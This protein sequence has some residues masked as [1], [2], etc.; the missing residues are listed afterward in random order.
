[1]LRC[2][3][4]LRQSA[5]TAFDRRPLRNEGVEDDLIVPYIYYIYYVIRPHCGFISTA[6]SEVTFCPSFFSLSSFLS[7]LM[8]LFLF[9]I[10]IHFPLSRPLPFYF[11][12]SLSPFSF[13][14]SFTVSLPFLS[15]NMKHTL[16][17]LSPLLPWL[18]LSKW[19]FI[20]RNSANLIR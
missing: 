19:H 16:I 1:M 3:L 8:S 4:C 13:F 6:N 11:L 10:F 20:S 12:F 18:R 14:P 15:L 7:L 9:S 2:C 5:C 17:S